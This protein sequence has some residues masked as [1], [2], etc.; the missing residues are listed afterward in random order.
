MIIYM[1]GLNKYVT[2]NS[3]SDNRKK[4]EVSC[5]V[6]QMS[7]TYLKGKMQTYEEF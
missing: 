4:D 5:F 7:D 2:N 6:P 1:H 3:I